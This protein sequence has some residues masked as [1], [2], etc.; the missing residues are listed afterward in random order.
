[1]ECPLLFTVATM[2]GQWSDGKTINYHKVYSRPTDRLD[3]IVK[4]VTNKV[5]EFFLIHRFLLL[6][7]MK[8]NK[9]LKVNCSYKFN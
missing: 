2:G 9:S 8:H 5:I 7:L 4:F 1:M 6:L 3:M